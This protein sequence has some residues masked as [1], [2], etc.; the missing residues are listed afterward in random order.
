DETENSA[1][2][3]H[4]LICESGKDI[5]FCGPDFRVGTD[6]GKWKVRQKTDDGVGDAIECNAASNHV[7]VAT[8][9]FLPEIFG[10]HGNIR[11]LFFFRQKIATA[12]RP[13][14]EHIEIVRGHP[15]TE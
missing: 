1:A 13:N 14:T 4:L 3:H 6:P 7:W 11:A 12:N 15:A 9:S 5:R 2:A 10:D 8:H